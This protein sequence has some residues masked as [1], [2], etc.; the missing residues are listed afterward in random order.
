MAQHHAGPPSNYDEDGVLTTEL[1]SLSEL[2]LIRA[3]A[4]SSA[5]DLQ[6]PA[7]TVT[8][9]ET[10]TMSVTDTTAVNTAAAGNTPAGNIRVAA[11][12]A[13]SAAEGDQSSQQASASA[14]PNVG[15]WAE[16]SN[17]IARRKA[18]LA[19][20]AGGSSAAANGV[21]GDESGAVITEC[22]VKVTG[23]QTP[24]AARPRGGVRA[25]AMGPMLAFL[26]SSGGL[27]GNA[28]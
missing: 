2:R 14:V 16:L 25:S 10:I 22:K 6:A 27:D 15:A 3:A 28:A 7:A 17:Q 11:A 18:E 9:T 26:R 4:Q 21:Q 5:T 12:A 20:K 13:L 24:G 8:P 23:M 19:S 1:S